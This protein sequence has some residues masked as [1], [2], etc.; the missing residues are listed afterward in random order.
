MVQARGDPRLTQG[1]PAGVLPLFVGQAG[2]GQQLLDRDHPFQAFVAGPP[3]N[4]HRPAADALQQPVVTGDQ[5]TFV[6]DRLLPVC[7]VA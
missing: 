7:T 6:D 4:P 1:T 5:L 3:H 2:L